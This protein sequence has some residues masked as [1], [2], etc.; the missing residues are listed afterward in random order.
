MVLLFLAY[1]AENSHLIPFFAL[2]II[3]DSVKIA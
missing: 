3:L 1:Q 2:D